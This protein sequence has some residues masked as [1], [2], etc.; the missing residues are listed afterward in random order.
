[1]EAT[2]P[3]NMKTR[4]SNKRDKRKE[5]HPKKKSAPPFK[6]EMGMSDHNSQDRHA[7]VKHEHIAQPEVIDLDPEEPIKEEYLMNGQQGKHNS[8]YR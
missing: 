8:Y 7:S 5:R 4:T 6:Q 1:M 3:L 2:D